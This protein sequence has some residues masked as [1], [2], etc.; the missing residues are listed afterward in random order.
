M[1]YLLVL[2]IAVALGLLLV[3]IFM[4]YFIS[5]GNK[6]E[7]ALTDLL[8]HDKYKEFDELI[9][10]KNTKTYV[11]PYNRDYLKL[12]KAFKRND[13]KEIDNIF[14]R[15]DNVRL[16]NRQKEEMYSLAFEYYQNS[17]NKQLTKKYH[18]LIMDMDTKDNSLK[19]TIDRMYDTYELN[20][21][22]YLEDSLE[23]L[24]MVPEDYAPILEGMISS[25]YKNKGDLEKA[26]EY[27]ELSKKHFE[28]MSIRLEE[29]DGEDIY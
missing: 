27:K 22:K 1:K 5:H 21:Y 13:K 12:N 11:R 9:E 29:E 23:E 15:F 14:K 19:N 8:A 4:I 6:I 16:N 28:E 26:K 2:G 24:E 17:G 10:D 7:Y 25:M 3:A 20:G 18:D